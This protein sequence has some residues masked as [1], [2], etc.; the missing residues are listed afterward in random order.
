MYYFICPE[1][2]CIQLQ[3]IKDYLGVALWANGLS[4]TWLQLWPVSFLSLHSPLSNINKTK[5]L[6]KNNSKKK[7]ATLAIWK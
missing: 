3:Y 6:K 4:A 2:N 7:G 1:L 5:T